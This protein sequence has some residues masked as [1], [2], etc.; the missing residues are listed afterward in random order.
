M[1]NPYIETEQEIMNNLIS[2][3][4]L[5]I[6]LEPTHPCDREDFADGIHELQ[7]ILGMRILR[8]DYPDM[9]PTKIKIKNEVLKC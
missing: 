4:N 6:K 9:F 2:A 7:K 1:Q 8:R 5:F 3:Y